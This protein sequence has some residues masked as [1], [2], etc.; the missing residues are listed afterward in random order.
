MK[1]F[2]LNMREIGDWAKHVRLWSFIREEM[3][4]VCFF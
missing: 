3:A 4:I 1:V 2:S